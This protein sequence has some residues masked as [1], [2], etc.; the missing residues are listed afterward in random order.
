MPCSYLTFPISVSLLGDRHLA[1]HFHSICDLELSSIEKIIF[2]T[3]IFSFFGGCYINW[4]HEMVE[5]TVFIWQ[6]LFLF[7]KLNMY[8]GCYIK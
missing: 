3:L 4:M 8:L 1:T 5:T 2:F 6:K 7:H